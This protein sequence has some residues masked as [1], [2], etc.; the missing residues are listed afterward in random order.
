M[1]DNIGLYLNIDE[2]DSQNLLEDV[3]QNGNNITV[4]KLGE[5][6]NGKPFAYISL[7][8]KNEQKLTFK[9]LPYQ[10]SMI[11]KNSSICKY[12]LGDNF[13]TLSLTQFREA[14]N[15]ISERLGIDLNKATVCRIDIA[16]NFFMKYSPS[17][18][19]SCL[20]H[21]SR[22]VRGAINGNLYFKT[23]RKELNFYDK[24][25]EYRQKRVKIPDAFKDAENV[26]R[27]EIRFKKNLKK[28]F[29]QTVTISDL[30]SQSFFEKIIDKWQKHY[31]NITKQN[32]IVFDSESSTF[33][34]SDFRDYFLVKGIE[35]TGGLEYVYT[36]INE[37]KKADAITSSKASYL[38]RVVSNA[39][40]NPAITTTY[41]FVEEL[42]EKMR[43]FKPTY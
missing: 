37:S 38:R 42:D 41:N 3:L 14:I 31:W 24:K 13:Q 6:G 25:K 34:T 27:Y 43:L 26:L 18:Y 35:A 36:T 15:E 2:V 33:K 20:N 4:D 11:G 40:E 29:G 28:Q 21:L 19:H 22:H 32:P 9:V 30:C 23:T 17:S 7:I 1:Y 39:Y 16:T 8:G 5:N 12:Y 10:I